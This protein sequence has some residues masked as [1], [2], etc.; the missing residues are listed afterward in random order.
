MS[1]SDTG[2]IARCPI[3][4]RARNRTTII[5][6]M[7]IFSK[8]WSREMV[9]AGATRHHSERAIRKR[10]MLRVAVFEEHVGEPAASGFRTREFEEGIGRVEA[11]RLGA[12]RRQC[13]REKAGTTRD[14]EHAIGRTYLDS[15]D[16]AREPPLLWPG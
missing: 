2:W 3:T 10:Q 15:A 4:P 8:I 11:H 13:H 14:I 6:V 9:E 12:T 7:P 5:P 1:A 16:E